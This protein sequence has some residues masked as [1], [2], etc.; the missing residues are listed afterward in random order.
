MAYFT[1]YVHDHDAKGHGWPAGSVRRA[2]GVLPAWPWG[3]RSHWSL[4]ETVTG[5]NAKTTNKAHAQES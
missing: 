2:R 5:K 4:K 1:K 3:E